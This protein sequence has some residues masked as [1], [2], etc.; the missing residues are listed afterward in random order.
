MTTLFLGTLL[1]LLAR[2]I[3]TLLVEIMNYSAVTHPILSPR[4]HRRIDKVMKSHPILKERAAKVVKEMNVLS[5]KTFERDYTSF[6]SGQ[7]TCDG[8]P[9]S[10][11]LKFQLQSDGKATPKFIAID[12][13]SDGSYW[14]Q[15]P[16]Q[17][18]PKS[19]LDWKVTATS[20]DLL[21]AESHGRQ[22]IPDDTRLDVSQDLSLH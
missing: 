8:K 22:I 1:A 9:C 19:Q 18:L 11:T 14:I 3:T 5:L 13:A 17:A 15:I 4:V 7:T 20:T 6:F 2:P 16:F 12:S 21:S 10:V